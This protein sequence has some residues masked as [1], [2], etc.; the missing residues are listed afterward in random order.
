MSL[1]YKMGRGGGQMLTWEGNLRPFFI[2]QELSQKGLRLALVQGVQP[3]PPLEWLVDFCG[4]DRLC[5]GVAGKVFTTDI[6]PSLCVFLWFRLI[7]SGALRRQS[8]QDSCWAVTL[9]SFGRVFHGLRGLS[10]VGEGGV[11]PV[12]E[13]DLG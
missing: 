8:T 7:R 6:S 11:C 4:Q 5:L 3:P 13:Q 12:E 10:P 9:A 2:S 1:I